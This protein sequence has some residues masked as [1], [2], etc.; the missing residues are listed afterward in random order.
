MKTNY[1]RSVFFWLIVLTGFLSQ[2]GHAQ[3]I[4]FDDFTYSGVTDG[5][6][7]SFNKW[8]I[9]NGTSG[10]P[11]GGQYRSDN[12]AFIADPASATNKLMTLSTTVNGQTKATTHARI[13]T[14]GFEYFEGTYSAR[15]YLSDVP[16]TYKD[17]NVQTFYSIVNSSLANDGS[18]YS[19]LDFVEYMAADKWGISPDNK[20]LYIT[21]WNRYIP[22][23]WQAWKR[24]FSY[25]QS[26]AGW[27]TFTASCTDG[28]N[29]KYWIDNDYKG[30]QST[31]DNDG[32]SVYPRSPMQVAFANWIWNSVVGTNTANRTTTM[33]VDW[34]LFSK[35]QELTP[36]QVEAQVATYRSQGLQRRNLAG[37]TY[38]TNPNPNQ[39]PVVNLTTPANGATFTAPASIIINGTASDSDGSISKV[40]FFNGATSLGSD[41]SSPYSVSWTSVP[42]G[43][44][45]ITAVATDNAGATAVSGAASITVTGVTSSNLALNKPTTVSS[46]ETSTL[47]G[48]AAVDGN[49]ATRWA[50]LYTDPQWIYVD[51]GGNY[52]IERVRLNWEAAYASAYQIDVSNDA[53][54]WNTIYSTSTGNGAVDDLTGLSGSGRY[55]RMYGTTRGAEWGYSLWDFEVYGSAATGNNLPAVTITGPAPGS[56]YTA[57]ATININATASDS[58]GSI[59]QVA[60]YNGSQLLGTDNTSP[61]S[62]SWTNVP[63]GSYSVK[64]IATDNGGA[65][66]TSTTVNITVTNPSSSFDQV[67]QAESYGNMGGVSLEPT[68]D[69]GA[70]QNVAYIDT[71]DWMSYYNITIPTSGNYTVQYR[72]ASLNAGG[73]LSLDVNAGATLLGM[74]DLPSTGGWQTWA[75]VS[76]TVYINAGTYNFGI[77]AQTGGWNINWWRITGASAAAA[78]TASDLPAAAGAIKIYPNPSSQKIQVTAPYDIER[79]AVE[80]RDA[81]GLKVFEGVYQPTGIDISQLK[82]GLYLL[83]IRKG[84]VKTDV[85]FVKE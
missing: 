7:S 30:A 59:T 1:R 53:T 62:Y 3:T 66:A 75:T 81:N 46:I 40:E 21:S 26:Y 29:V 9:V 8:S 17:G 50:S 24:Y 44:Y 64:A 19:E 11:E 77:Y 55:V 10:P 69:T 63:A 38:V 23:P 39:P 42:A 49:S 73:K 4:M 74:L 68:T 45:S 57:P 16:F 52:S 28:V 48:P 37:N 36:Q 84:D 15:V 78:S 56:S 67:I 60:F 47:T 54:N 79:A 71:N 12:I 2:T 18:R 14:S 27:H 51:L 65:T 83:K 33:Q 70:G 35:N 58:D 72:V 22:E 13:E 80:I 20:V 41:T 61:Y 25:Q 76:H 5:Q 82:K 32:T 34:V 43:T 31:T 6:L 85:R